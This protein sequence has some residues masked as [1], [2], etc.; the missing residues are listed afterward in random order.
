MNILEGF[1]KFTSPGGSFKPKISIRKRGQIGI[2]SGTI[3]RFKLENIDYVV[4]YISDDR[5]KVAFKFTNDADDEGAIKIVKRKGNY[6]FSG[7]SFL[8]CYGISYDETS[9][10]D[11]ECDDENKI[12]IID[13]EKPAS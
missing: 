5:T 6:Y 7:V 1:E 3:N 9:T 10:Y 11:V 8:D 13:I 2:N 4:M 12:G